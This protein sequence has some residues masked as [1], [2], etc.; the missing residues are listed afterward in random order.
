MK[1]KGRAK[2]NKID[3][4]RGP[5]GAY[6]SGA[7]GQRTAA[8]R[9]SDYLREQ[10]NAKPLGAQAGFGKMEEAHTRDRIS[11]M[12]SSGKGLGKSAASK[13]NR[14]AERAIEEIKKMKKGR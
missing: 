2:S 5:T 3:D 7:I 12:K 8:R 11:N 14:N 13:V 6:K 9:E 4:V 1:T 10:V